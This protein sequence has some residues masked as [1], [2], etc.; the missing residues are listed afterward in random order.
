MIRSS[1]AALAF[2][3]CLAG[4]A[5]AQDDPAFAAGDFMA[6]ETS[7]QDTLK[8]HR[9]DANALAGLAR[10]RL[11]QERVTE[12]RDLAKRALAADANNPIAPRVLMTA[13]MRDASFATSVYQMT[14]P[15]GGVTVPFTGTDPLPTLTVIVGGKPVTF[16]IDTGAPDLVIDTD[17]AK[18][19]GLATQAGG[20]GT[21]AGGQHAMSAH[22]TLP[23]ITLGGMTVRNIPVA[24]LPTRNFQLRPGTQIDGIVGTGFLRHFLATIDYRG[25]ALILKPRSGSA[26]FEAAAAQHKATIVPM[27]LTGDH[28]LF[29]RAHINDGPEG[30]FNIDTGLAGGGLQGTKATLDAAHVVTDYPHA[31]MSVGGGGMVKV[32]PF[33]ANATL[34][35]LTVKDVAGAYTP[36]GDQFGIFPF[37]VAGTLS[38][39]FFRNYALTFD[40]VAMRLVVR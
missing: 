4:S 14:I 11:Y 1:I 8:Q 5:T 10:I 2:L 22:A 6:A 15:K 36:D 34:G 20:Q 9:D 31:Q 16:V 33:K 27:W 24:V 23:E 7:Y 40:F 37:K 19:L 3:L 26:A 39:D 13:D 32:V 18:E 21:F 17:F 25:G 38:H 30:L 29:A 35:T 12:S 28:F